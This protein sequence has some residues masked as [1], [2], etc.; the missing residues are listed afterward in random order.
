MLA[1]D[2]IKRIAKKKKVT[3]GI[4]IAI[5]AFGRDLKRNVHIHL[6]V[7]MGGLSDDNTKWIKL[8]FNR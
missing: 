4:F 3:P 8:F 1:V 5:H 2:C 7:T 6:F